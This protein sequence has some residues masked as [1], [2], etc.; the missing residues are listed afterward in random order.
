MDHIVMSRARHSPSCFFRY[1]TQVLSGPCISEL[2]AAMQ[3]R[4]SSRSR[5]R[6]RSFSDCRAAA[7]L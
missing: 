6:A 4:Q 2:R 7:G 5:F 3:L 1:S